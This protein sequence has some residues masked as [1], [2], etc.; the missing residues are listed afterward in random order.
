[1]NRDEAIKREKEILTRVL[2]G[3]RMESEEAV[4]LWNY[5]RWTAMVDAAHQ[6]RKKLLG[7]HLVGYTIYR[8]V[9]YTSVCKVTCSFCSFYCD[10]TSKRGYTMTPDEMRAIARDAQERG[11]DQIFFQGGVNPALDLNYFTKAF[12]IFTQDFGMTVR[13][14]SPVEVIEL[15]KRSDMTLTELLPILKEAGLSSVPGAGA[16][17]LSD[18]IRSVLSPRKPSVADWANAMRCCHQ[19]GLPGSA[20]IVFGSI[21]TP[22][23]I[24]E[25]LRIIRDIQDETGGFF[26]FVPWTFQP[27]TERF[28]ICP[29][30][31][32]EYLK[33]VALARLWFDNIRHIEVSLLGQGMELGELALRGGADDIN[34][35]VIEENVLKSRGPASI[36]A[37]NDFIQQAGFTPRRRNF[38]FHPV[39]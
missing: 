13:G 7:D 20:N 8:V 24:V 26:S 35:V 21:E 29:V 11:I 28:P 37:A 23:E 30:R 39:E 9:N 16:E 38:S 17:V 32:D 19:A 1:V 2:A 33:M 3:E 34:S 10:A 31:G 15:A 22:E 4:F 5:G 14:L 36:Q 25:H 12:Q 18:R 27:Q 6:V